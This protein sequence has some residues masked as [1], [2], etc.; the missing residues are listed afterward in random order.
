MGLHGELMLDSYI[1]GNIHN[2]LISLEFSA[3]KHPDIENSNECGWLYRSNE[4]DPESDF[5]IVAAANEPWT[6]WTGEAV[7]GSQVNIKCTSCSDESDCSYQGKCK[8]PNVGLH[9]L[10]SHTLYITVTLKQIGVNEQCVCDNNREGHFC[11][12][13]KPCAMLATEKA[14]KVGTHT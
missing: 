1:V 13:D 12:F 2:Y 6:A 5:D 11:E 8:L 10:H 9:S 14:E 4:V 3:N 7:F